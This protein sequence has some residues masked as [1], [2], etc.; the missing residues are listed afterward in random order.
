MMGV[1]PPGVAKAAADAKAAAEAK[2]AEAKT[3]ESKPE[4]AAAAEAAKPEEKK[5]EEKKSAFTQTLAMGMTVPQDLIPTPASPAAEPMFAPRLKAA[6]TCCCG[7]E[8]GAKK[9]PSGA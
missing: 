8:T 3:P 6:G 2:A 5:P 1:A 4:P 9:V 7:V